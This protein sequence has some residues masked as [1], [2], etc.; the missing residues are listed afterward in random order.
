MSLRTRP[1]QPADAS[2]IARI[3]NEGIEDRVAT[4]ETR[5]RTEDDVRPWFAEGFPLVVV[6]EEGAL[7]AWASAP[8]Y[9]RG[10]DVYREVA[11]FSVYVA[12]AGRRRGVGRAA[13]EALLAEAEA[14]GFW[15]LVGRIFPENEASLSLCRR[16]GFREVGFHRRHGKLDGAWRDV[17]VVERLLGEA[18]EEHQPS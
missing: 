18:A 6:E 15:K 4:F 5:P 14:R 9:S 17:V 16:L 10:R 13:M 12:R 3:Y 7:I 1:A 2:A 11:D 8:P